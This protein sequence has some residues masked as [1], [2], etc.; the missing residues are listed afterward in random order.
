MALMIADVFFSSPLVEYIFPMISSSVSRWTLPGM[1]EHL[2]YPGVSSLGWGVHT[3]KG[4]EGIE[5]IESQ[6]NSKG[7]G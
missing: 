6:E 4:F 7:R 5:P 3:S 2:G 1:E